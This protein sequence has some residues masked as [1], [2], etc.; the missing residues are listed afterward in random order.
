[1]QVVPKFC[2]QYAQVGMLINDALTDY[3][4]DVENGNFPNKQFSPYKMAAGQL[5]AFVENLAKD[6]FSDAAEAAIHASELLMS[7]S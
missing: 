3:R 2:K 7:E 4:D 1:M 5:D 6:G